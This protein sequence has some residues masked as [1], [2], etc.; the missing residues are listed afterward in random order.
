MRALK[1]IVGLLVA[2]IVVVLAVG[3]FLPKDYRV[4]RSIEIDCPPE[5]VFE[6]VNS[7][8][9]WSAWSPWIARDP[10]ID[11][12]YSGPEAGV[13]SKVA[14]TSE[15]SGAGIQTITLSEPAQRIETHLDFGEMGQAQS[16]WT[17]EPKGLGVVVTWGLSG[18][19]P[20]VLG[21]YFARMM[22]GWVGADYE[23]GLS[24]LKQ[25]VG[26][27]RRHDES[28]NQLDII[29]VDS[30]RKPPGAAGGAD[31]R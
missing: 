29:N 22:D 7:L 8:Q 23:D 1:I 21:G 26:E 14:W 11:S 16:D 20:G 12:Q 31:G 5:W 27:K 18:N 10:T 19:A 30:E 2:V 25:V 6:E 17:F 28:P 9:R 13:G 4:E 15:N 24:R 3:L